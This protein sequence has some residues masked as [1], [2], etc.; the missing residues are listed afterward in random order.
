MKAP[1]IVLEGP[2]GSGK[3]WQAQCLAERLRTEGIAHHL[4]AEPTTDDDANPMGRLLRAFLRGEETAPDPRALQLL[5]CAD[6]LEHARTVIEPARAEGKVVVCDRYDLST[7]AYGVLDDPSESEAILSW[8]RAVGRWAPR[9]TLTV[10]LDVT[11]EVCAERRRARG[12]PPET[13][14]R[15]ATQARLVGL[16]GRAKTLLPAYDNVAWVNGIGAREQV[17]ARV[18]TVVDHVLRPWSRYLA[19]GEVLDA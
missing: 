8:L 9:P 3:S 13:F 19:T 15:E 14:D 12:G 7:L 10:V 2:D 6:R 1:F 5:F 16:Y 4:T 18:W 11:A 17:A